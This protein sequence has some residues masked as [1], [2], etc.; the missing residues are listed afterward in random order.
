MKVMYIL[1]EFLLLFT[2]YSKQCTIFWL[3]L[4]EKYQSLY[5]HCDDKTFK[6]VYIKLFTV[7]IRCIRRMD[8]MLITDRT[9]KEC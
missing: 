9:Q 5:L 7:E 4:I 2:V 1:R 3:S 6:N 8:D